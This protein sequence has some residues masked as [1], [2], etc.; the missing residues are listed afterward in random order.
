[1]PGRAAKCEIPY[2]YAGQRTCD[3]NKGKKTTTGQLRVSRIV[4]QP[5]IET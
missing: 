1:M 4:L 5:L 2:S 3:Y